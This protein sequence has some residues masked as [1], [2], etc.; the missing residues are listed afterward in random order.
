MY[1]IHLR[2]EGGKYCLQ[3]TQYFAIINSTS[4]RVLVSDRSFL[5]SSL[6]D[7]LL[8]HMLI[9]TFL[10]SQLTSFR[11]FNFGL[12]IFCFTLIFAY[13]SLEGFCSSF[14]RCTWWAQHNLCILVEHFLLD[15]LRIFI[16]E[17]GQ[18]EYFAF[19]GAAYWL[20]T[21][22]VGWNVFINCYLLIWTAFLY[23]NIYMQLSITTFH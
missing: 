3:S 15:G 14:I 2:K 1:V 20:Y 12:P 4:Q 8:R 17:S 23:W 16:W 21:E 9:S 13:R 22:T 19:L 18:L 5:R 11:Q 7:T 6:S 10:A